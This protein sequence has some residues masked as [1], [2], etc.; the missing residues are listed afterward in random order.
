VNTTN[1][2]GHV[3]YY[4]NA[5]CSYTVGTH[6]WKAGVTDTRYNNTNTSE[7]LEINITGDL[8][9]TILNPIGGVA[10][11]Y[12]R[13]TN[14]TFI[15]K[16]DSDCGSEVMN[17]TTPEFR[18]SNSTSE[19]Y[20][21]P[22]IDQGNGTYNCSLNTSNLAT[23]WYNFTMNAS[24]LYYNP[25]T[26]TFSSAFFIETAPVLSGPNISQTLGGWGETFTFYVN[27]TDED[28]DQLNIRAWYQQLSPSVGPWTEITP[29]N[30]SQGLNQTVSFLKTFLFTEIGNHTFKFNTTDDEDD[31]VA[32]GS[33]YS[34]EIAAGFNYT[35]EEDDTAMLYGESGNGTSV[36]RATADTSTLALLLVD[37]DK[38]NET[39]TSSEQGELWVTTN[40]SDPNSWSRIFN[41]VFVGNLTYPFNPGCLFGVGDQ[42]WKGG[43]VEGG[44]TRYKNSNSSEY[45]ITITSEYTPEVYY[46]KNIS[47]DREADDIPLS[48]NLSD[49]TPDCGVDERNVTGATV[50]FNT[51]NGEYFLATDMED[52]YYNYTIPQATVSG[53]TYGWYNVSANATRQYYPQDVNTTY[54][55]SFYLASKP[56]LA[57]ESMTQGLCGDYW[58]CPANFTVEVTDNDGNN[59]TVQ[60]WKK[61]G[62]TGDWEYIGEGYCH[63]CSSTEIKVTTNFSCSDVGSNWYKFNEAPLTHPS[64]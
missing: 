11:I 62:V 26:T 3:E 57:S 38:N 17:D 10:G 53:W 24:K 59:V 4:Y 14:I 37:T 56:S 43:R 40:A 20:C 33:Q 28:L 48:M 1:S 5:T 54:N 2:S 39:V 16:L 42:L 50:Y 61:V 41:N 18:Y 7:Y 46:P 45:N 52:G 31:P 55:Y 49:N 6:Q 27:A 19:Y 29:S 44:S 9:S 32:G 47:F 64:L 13:G 36:N 8:Y 35:V 21:T 34:H 58:G 51:N 23:R 15:G 60:L 63:P 12:L 25:N 30:T 22:V